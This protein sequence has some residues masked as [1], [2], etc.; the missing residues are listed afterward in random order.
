MSGFCVL[1]KGLR[2]D[3]CSICMKIF[4]RCSIAL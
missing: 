1:E 2:Q 3:F 4:C